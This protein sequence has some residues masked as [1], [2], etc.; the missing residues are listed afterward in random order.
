[1]LRGERFLHLWLDKH[2]YEYDV[3]TDHDLHRNPEL[4]KGYQAVV[5]NGHSEY[6]SA[7]AYDGFDNYLKAGGAAVVMSGNTMF[8]RVS[9]DETGE[10]ME[11]RKFGKSIGGRVHAKVGELYHSHDFKRGSLMRFCGYPAWKLVGL[12][13]IGWGGG[14]FKPYRADLPDHF[15]FNEPYKIDLKKGDAFGFVNK[16]IGAVGHEFDVRLSTLLRATKNP[17]LKGLVEPKGMLTIASSHDKRNILDFNAD[18]HKQRVGG[19]QTI[20]EIIYWERPQGG[21]IFHTGSIA[22]AW[23]MYHDESLGRLVKNV[24]HHFKVTPKKRP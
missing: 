17:A 21:R 2:G 11:C 22:T 24:L 7:R 3:V 4:L 1:L 20:A 8:W 23:A 13:C 18:A 12:T 10:V 6:W 9:F 5:V 19:E 14:N 15:L 16:S